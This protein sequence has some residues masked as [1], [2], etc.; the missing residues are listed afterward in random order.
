[1]ATRRLSGIASSSS[2]PDNGGDHS[3]GG[4]GSAGGASDDVFS[5]YV[6]TGDSTDRDIENGIDLAGE[7]GL[8]WGKC[9]TSGVFD[10]QLI[11]TERGVRKVLESNSTDAEAT[12]GDV[13]AF[14][15][16]GFSLS[17]AASGGN[18]L[19][20]SNGQDFVTWTFR[21]APK[22]FDVV[23]YT[24]D[25]V[26]GR[27]I[28]HN[29]GIEPGMIIVKRLESGYSWQVYHR[30]TD[31]VA[32]ENYYLQ[33]DRPNA[34]E[35]DTGNGR[36]G[37]AAPTEQAFTVG[38]SPATNESGSEHIAYLFAHDDSDESIIK[39]GGYSHVRGTDTEIDLGWEPQFAIDKT[40]T[41]SDNWYM[42]DVMRGWCS[43]GVSNRLNPNTNFTESGSSR[44]LTSTGFVIPSGNDTHDGIYMAIRRPTK[45]A[46]EYEPEELFA[47]EPASSSATPPSFTSGFPVDFSIHRQPLTSTSSLWVGGRMIQGMRLYT[48]T[49]ASE[50]RDDGQYYDYMEGYNSSPHMTNYPAWMWRRAPGFFDVVAYTGSSGSVQAIRHNLGVAPEM[51]WIKNRDSSQSWQVY[52]PTDNNQGYLFL[53]TNAKSSYYSY[54]WGYNPP[55][56]TQ[57]EVNVDIGTNWT[58]A[59]YIAYLFA[60]VPGIS[61][62]GSY[63]GNNGDQDID[64][65][66]TNGARFVLIKRTDSVGDWMF[67]DTE[68]GITASS[69]P[70][71]RLNETDA[72]ATG[73]YIK[74]HSKGFTA[75]SNLTSIGK[76]EYIFYAI[77]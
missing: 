53:D 44:Y 28:P 9:R 51:M 6:Y 4:G 48:N 62:V 33:L 8:V 46:S 47:I 63:T 17:G 43:S 18:N 21:K 40:A 69:S 77:A 23:T 14:N 13:S 12:N 74:P 34:R 39:C 25:G 32:P 24:G 64:C 2:V 49:G 31:A 61:K 41:I 57:F 72:Q 66:F 45:P 37:G 65:G 58:N 38:N 70:I 68:R 3:G 52:Y 60:S 22:F 10:H 19:L 16:D 20:I 29:L 7:G 71:L 73:S 15:S 1:M 35:V 11:D 50:G 42:F 5:T 36:W 54:A 56:E 59:G 55:N 30:G 76:A 75:T 26:D 27:D 67:F